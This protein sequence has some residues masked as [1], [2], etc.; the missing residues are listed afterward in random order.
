MRQTI[1]NTP[2]EEYLRILG[3]GMVTIPKQWRDELGLKE[4]LIVKAQKMGNK[5]II[6]AKL[7]SLPYRIFSDEEIE[8]WL[9]E[10]RLSN[11]LAKKVDA[12]LN[13]LKS[14]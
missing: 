3:K 13:V 4:G 1:V 14:G 9:K 11:S 8:Q 10:D 5:M 2:Q 7:E 12:K 6:E